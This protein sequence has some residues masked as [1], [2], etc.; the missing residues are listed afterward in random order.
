MK[1][2][3]SLFHKFVSALGRLFEKLGVSSEVA[4]RVDSWVF[5]LLLIVL[6][7]ILSW[8]LR[9]VLKLILTH[10]SKKRKSRVLKL[11]VKHN[12]VLK[13]LYVI[14][15]IFIL[16]FL[17]L[18]YD[19]YP[20]FIVVSERI[21]W[22][23]FIISITLYVNY[24]LSVL[25]SV[26]GEQGGS[27]NIPMHGLVQLIKVVIFILAFIV[28][29]AIAI[30]KSPLNLITGLG[31]FA[32]VLMLIFKDTILGLVSGVQLMQNDIIRKGDWITTSND[33][34]NGIVEDITLNTVKVG[35]FDNTIV[36][37]PPYSLVSSTLQNWRSM[38]ES[39]ARR[40]L[41]TLTI[42]IETIKALS[43]EQ[44][45]EWK[46]VDILAT[47][48]AQKEQERVDG[49]RMNPGDVNDI[50]GT[51]DT[52]L[53]LFRAYMQLYINN[54]PLTNKSMLSMVRLLDSVANGIPLQIYC[55]STV[56]E[57]KGYEAVRSEITEYA[58][59]MSRKFGL[60]IYQNASGFH[61]LS[62][63]YITVGK[64]IPQ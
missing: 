32:A 59:D 41:I 56:T 53:G 52:N 8:V 2:E 4:E 25:W 44:L 47:F 18:A 50:Y 20:K 3:L 49:N 10:L 22:I 60:R 43:V 5:V 29:V 57:W 36:T 26:V 16:P 6:A 12:I 33:E 13:F 62:E 11:L 35:N 17:P 48:I 42:E 21:C 63:A 58:C 1:E 9:I 46:R 55:F 38:Q 40:I 15:P 54:H 31:A 7:I 27:K 24:L 51:I 23:Y 45:N 14:P 28:I 34:I 61:Y 39:G 19:D 37:I 30:N 64:N